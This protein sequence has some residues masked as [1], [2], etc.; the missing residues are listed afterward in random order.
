MSLE[1]GAGK[2]V[3]Y[4]VRALGHAI[5]PTVTLYAEDGEWSCDCGGKFDP[6]SH[7]AAAVISSTQGGLAPGAGQP[8]VPTGPPLPPA[9]LEYRLAIKNRTLTL[10]RFIVHQDGK[11]ERLGALSSELARG[12]LPENL[13]PTHDD[14]LVDR[15][16][17]P[18]RRE[19]LPVDRLQE[20]FSALSNSGRVMLGPKTVKVSGELVLPK[21]T[22]EDAPNGGFNLRLERDTAISEVIAMGVARCGSVLRPLGETATTGYFLER[23]PMSRLFTREQQAD[24]VTRVLPEL[25]RKL[26]L[27]VATRK[28]PRANKEV[29]PRIAMDL[30]HHGH[31]LSV[32]PTLV[33]GD[34]A[35]LRIDG[36]EAVAVGDAAPVRRPDEERALLRRLR[37]ELN[38]VP[39]R[40]VDLDG[41][42]A[43]RFAAKLREWQRRAGDETN[44]AVFERRPLTARLVFDGDSFDVLFECDTGK[45]GAEAPARADAVTVL[46]AWR[47]GLDLVPL[48][49]GGWAPLPAA[50]LAEHGHRVADLLAARNSDK[51]LPAA[52]FPELGALCDAL[53][54]PKPPGFDK[55]APLLQDFSGIASAPLPADLNAELR[56]YQQFGVDW[57]TFLRSAG[58]GAVLAD[59][60]GLGKTLQTL[61]VLSGRALVVCPKSVVYNWAEE[62]TRFRPGLR[63]AIYHGSK[64]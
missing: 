52:V 16:L 8:V 33:Y 4:R 58:L 32:L 39:G 10:A 22:V 60:M 47:D 5:A 38:L 55:L 59:D 63:T 6:C 26:P 18:T 23:L 36:N 64:R 37:D 27:T 57:L 35:V 31:T 17:G 13:T 30:S 46:R 54:T 62:I 24:L 42:E 12:S 7:V 34:P 40:R 50:W 51:K 44:A 56:T 29:R 45:P 53:D 21:A 3:T 49:G 20:L 43:L 15:I 61:C 28:L 19:L 1:S 48:Q 11:E 9:R 14:L 41:A 2:E 25:E